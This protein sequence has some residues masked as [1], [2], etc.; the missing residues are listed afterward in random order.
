MVEMIRKYL[1]K[2]FSRWEDALGPVAFAYRN[3]VLSS[4]NETPYFLNHGRDPVLP[5]DRFS[6][7]QIGLLRCPQTTRVNYYKKFMKRLF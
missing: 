6:K 1:E 7:S 5:V 3:S 4:T 2:A